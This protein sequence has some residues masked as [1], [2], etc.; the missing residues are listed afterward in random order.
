MSAAAKRRA[1][2]DAGVRVFARK[3]YHASRVSDIAEDAGVA[4]GLLYHYFDSKEELLQTIFRET[5][6]LMLDTI[7]G[8]EDLGEPAPEQLR[9]VAAIVLR[10]W[11]DT[12]D[13][14]RVLVR[15]VTRS[16]QLQQEV[17]EIDQ[18]FR[19]LERIIARGQAMGE[20]RQDLDARFAS[21]VFYGALEELLTGWVLGQLPDSDEDIARAE[22]TVVETLC[23]GMLAVRKPAAAAK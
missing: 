17:L 3:G 9:K 7:K 19:T 11:R 18:A 21:F 12:P 15:E 8:V 20:F 1:L 16:P 2:L 14:V 13:V 5:W 4:H 23:D 10:A 6:T 22:R